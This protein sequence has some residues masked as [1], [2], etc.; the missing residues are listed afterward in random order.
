MSVKRT[1]IALLL[2]C[3]GVGISSCQKLNVDPDINPAPASDIISPIAQPDPII[4]NMPNPAVIQV[5]AYISIQG[6][7]ILLSDSTTTTSG[8]TDHLT[9]TGYKGKPGDHFNFTDDGKLYTTEDSKNDTA[10]Y[11]ITRDNKI[12]LNFTNQPDTAKTYGASLNVFNPAKLTAKCIT[13]VSA[14]ITTEG[15]TYRTIQLKK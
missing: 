14:V 13:L 11:T 1:F 7:W 15:A 3:L 10:S 5:K 6:D 9:A 8:S 2:A 4:D 12:V